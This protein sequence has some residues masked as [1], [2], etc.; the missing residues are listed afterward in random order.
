MAAMVSM[1]MPTKIRKRLMSS[2]IR[3]LLEVRRSIA[4]AIMLGMCSLVRM[5]ANTFAKAT[6]AMIAEAEETVSFR[7]EYIS[8]GPILR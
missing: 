8:L 7:Q 2:R 4:S 1:N 5:K 6:R 3:Y